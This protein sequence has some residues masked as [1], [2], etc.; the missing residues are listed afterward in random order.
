M[1]QIGITILVCL[2]VLALGAMAIFGL[3][4]MLL[5][6]NSNGN[7]ANAYAS[8]CSWGNSTIVAGDTVPGRSDLVCN[9]D[10][11]VYGDEGVVTFAGF[12]G[13]S[14]MVPDPNTIPFAQSTTCGQYDI[15]FDGTDYIYGTAYA[16]TT[17]AGDGEVYI[18]GQWV[19]IH[20]S[21]SGEYTLFRNPTD[22]DVPYRTKYGAGCLYG[23]DQMVMVN[24]EFNNPNHD[25]LVA[26]R[27]VV[28]NANNT[29]TTKYFTK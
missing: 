22:T 2:T 12:Y 7:D 27:D 25:D 5:G 17:M 16:H 15:Q 21:G 26:V 13:E 9:Y 20:D 24:G 11:N 3:A 19:N 14:N 29:I 10:G 28:F 23:T 8:G 4:P 18:N 6:G 1:K